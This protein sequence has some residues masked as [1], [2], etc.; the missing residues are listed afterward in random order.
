MRKK[1]F[2]IQSYQITLLVVYSQM[3]SDYILICVA[4]LVV[5]PGECKKKGREGISEEKK[6]KLSECKSKDKIKRKILIKE[7]KRLAKEQKR[8]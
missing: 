1:G 5:V 7:K 6:N 8:K 3:V 2:N 4:S